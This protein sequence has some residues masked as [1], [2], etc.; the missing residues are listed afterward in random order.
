MWYVHEQINN[1]LRPRWYTNYPLLGRTQFSQYEPFLSNEDCHIVHY[2]VIQVGGFIH[3]V[4]SGTMKVVSL[5]A[6]V[7]LMHVTNNTTP[8]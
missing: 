4:D 5:C 8:L 7:L 1:P 3:K 2:K 6:A